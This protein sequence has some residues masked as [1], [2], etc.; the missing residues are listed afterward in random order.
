MNSLIQTLPLL[1]GEAG[2]HVVDGVVGH[3]DGR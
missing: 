2:V 1:L 3:G